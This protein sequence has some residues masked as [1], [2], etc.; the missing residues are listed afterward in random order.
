L[1]YRPDRESP[2]QSSGFGNPLNHLQLYRNPSRRQAPGKTFF[3]LFL[4]LWKRTIR[5]SLEGL[6]PQKFARQLY[7][8]SLEA[9]EPFAAKPRQSKAEPLPPNENRKARAG[10]DHKWPNIHTPKLETYA[11][12]PWGARR[13]TNRDFNFR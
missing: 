9:L 4:R 3:T 13:H 6:R 10:C 12:E 11:S 7:L 1:P 2:D 5:Q 8:F